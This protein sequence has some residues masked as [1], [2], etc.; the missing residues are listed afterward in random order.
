MTDRAQSATEG[1]AD[2]FSAGDLE[3]LAARGIAP[4]E[5]LRQLALLRGPEPFATL[6]RACT[7]GDGILRCEEAERGRFEAMSHDAFRAGRCTKFVPASGAASRM[8]AELERFRVRTDTLGPAVLEAQ[9]AAGAPDVVALLRFLDR[10]ERFPFCDDIVAVLPDARARARARDY[11][12]LLDTLLGPD[13]LDA[14]ARPKGLLPFHRDG[15]TVR[16]AFEEQLVEAAALVR[17]KGGRCRAHFTVSPEHQSGFEALLDAVR[18][19][20]GDV[21]YEVSFSVQQPSSDTLAIGEDGLPFHLSSG[22]LLFRPAGHGALIGNLNAL[23]AD[24]V[25]IKNIDNVVPDRLKGPT[26]AWSRVL[27]GL[28]ADMEAQTHE[29]VRRLR[30]ADHAEVVTEAA[31][32]LE[33]RFDERIPADATTPTRRDA[34]LRLLARPIRVCGMVPNTGEPGGGPYFARDAGYAPAPQIVEGAQVRMDDADQARIFREATHFNPVFMACAVRDD[35][36]RPFDLRAFV[37]P[38]AA[39]VT[40]KSAEGRPLKALERPGL[41]NGAMAGWNSIFVEVPIQ[42]FNPVKTVLDLL[43]AEHQPA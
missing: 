41:W 10:F 37:D 27:I 20:A 24:L 42:V 15:A 19:R 18:Q 3:Q 7:V 8:F 13:G 21:R 34:A 29:W 28:L 40:R 2:T 36:G 33:R 43:R 9:V 1:L 14:A 4:E 17:D 38:S 22:E 30:V 23:G 11:R 32:F 6:E 25:L 12:P 16:T 35:A 5:A 26:L 31:L 39:I